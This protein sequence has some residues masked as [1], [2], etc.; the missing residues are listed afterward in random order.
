[1]P[2]RLR[3][4]VR[5]SLLLLSLAALPL[6]ASAVTTR[7]DPVFAAQLARIAANAG[8]PGF[9]GAY[10]S[11]GRATFGVGAGGV[12]RLGDPAAV[13]PGDRFHIG[14]N[15]KAMSATVIAGLVRD[16]RLDWDSTLAAALPELAASMHPDFR[17]RT[18]RQLLTMRAGVDPLLTVDAIFALPVTG[19]TPSAQ[20]RD[21]ARLLLAAAPSTGIGV[22]Q[23]SNG[24][25]IVAGAI[26]ERTLGIAWE[27]AIARGVLAPLGVDGRTGWPGDGGADAPWGHLEIDGALVAIEPDSGPRFPAFAQPAGDL[28]MTAADLAAFVRAH[29]EGLTG[30]D[31][32]LG[33]TPALFATLH[34]TPDV[35]AMGWAELTET[36]RIS[37]FIGSTDLFT[38][39]MAFDRD[40]GVGAVFLVNADLGDSTQTALDAAIVA[41][42]ARALAVPE[43]ASWALLIAGFGLT[44]G[45]LRRQRRYAAH[46]K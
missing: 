12:R 20:R 21:A 23:Y 31:T 14:S 24:S 40:L 6:P 39:I 7:A 27:E 29:L 18:I 44:G 3:R 25:Y 30:D 37:L 17:A 41:G 42:F 10:F 11:T 46:A 5:A 43:P 4:A 9:T 26:I 28:S 13:T 22:E 16:G 2:A 33:L 8:L 15:V 1:M 45:V 36:G 35:L 34:E 19:E 32:A 38:G